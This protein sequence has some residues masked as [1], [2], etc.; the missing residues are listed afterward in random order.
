MPSTEKFSQLRNP[1]FNH[2]PTRRRDRDRDH[3]HL[4]RPPST[5]RHL[6]SRPQRARSRGQHRAPAGVDRLHPRACGQEELPSAPGLAPATLALCRQGVVGSIPR[7]VDKYHLLEQ[8]DQGV[9]GPPRQP[10]ELGHRP[11]RCVDHLVSD[12]SLPCVLLAIPG[13]DAQP[14]ASPPTPTTIRPTTL[15]RDST[16][17]R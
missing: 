13:I 6:T 7:P 4:R 15:S 11:R 2:P 16:R 8:T 1:P 14:K 5:H 3:R 17:P 12:R 10:V 9:A